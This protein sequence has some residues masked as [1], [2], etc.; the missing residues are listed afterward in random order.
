MCDIGTDMARTANTHNGVR[1]N[2]AQRR[3]STPG[4]SYFVTTPE[5]SPVV[6]G[7]GARLAPVYRW[8]H[9]AHSW[10]MPASVSRGT[11]RGTS[12]TTSRNS[13]NSRNS[14]RRV[15]NSASS[16]RSRGGARR[17][18]NARNAANGL[19]ALLTSLR[20]M[21]RSTRVRNLTNAERRAR[22]A[23]R[24]KTYNART[25]RCVRRR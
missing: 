11:S 8:Q 6:R 16:M 19:L 3:S 10:G 1:R 20:P 22:C 24:G 12:R 23:A 9:P 14:S 2:I 4:V 5:L 18:N 21:S 25:G 13:R 17:G 7:S 15:A